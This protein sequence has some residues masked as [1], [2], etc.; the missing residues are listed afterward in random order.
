[1]NEDQ[2]IKIAILGASRV[3]ANLAEELLS[4]RMAAYIPQCFIDNDLE[5]V[6]K[7]IRGIPVL[8]EDKAVFDKLR[9]YKVQEIVFAVPLLD[10][11]KKKQLYE[12]YKEAGFKIKVYDYPNMQNVG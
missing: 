9:D 12:K 6:G 8:A 7:E 1:M 5:K 3:G 4:N 11:E 2:K 10:V